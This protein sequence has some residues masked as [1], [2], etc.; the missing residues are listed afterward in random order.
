[1]CRPGEATGWEVYTNG[2]RR[3][4][5]IDAIEWAVRGV[6]MGAGEILLTSMDADGTLAGYDLALTK[7]VAQAVSVPVIASGGA[8]SPQ[9]FVDV[10]TIGHADAALAASLFHDGR[11]AIP[12]L[13]QF[14]AESGVPVRPPQAA[15]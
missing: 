8:G 14:L 1:M 12:T 2:G 4:T 15:S 13:K 7:A 11:L 3:P 5:G 10:L 6:E 9:D